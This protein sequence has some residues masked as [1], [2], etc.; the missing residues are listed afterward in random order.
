MNPSANPP[1]TTHLSIR[2]DW[3]AMQQ[4]DIIEPELPIVDA[5]H[6]LWDHLGNRY[7]L[8][9]MLA[10][11]SSGHNIRATVGVEC[12]SMY[13]QN[14][15]SELRPVGETEFLNGAAAMSAS[16]AYGE[17]RVAHGIVG[18]AN[19]CLGA[20]VKPVLEAHIRAGGGRFRGVRFSSVWHPDPAARGSLA[21]PPPFV[22]RDPKFQEGFAQ[23]APLGLSFDAW[24][25]HTQLPE[26][27]EL[28]QRFPETTIIL[29]HIGGAIGIGPYAGKRDAVLAEWRT[30]M[31]ELAGLKNVY[32]KLGGLG[33]RLAGFDFSSRARPPSSQ[34]L[35]VCWRPFI[36]TCI[37]IFGAERC[38]FE[39]NFPVDKGS[40][41]YAVLW[42]AFKRLA[43]DASF[44][45]KQALFSGTASKVYRL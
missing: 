40:F 24:L 12:N 41:S 37:E 38:M 17:C 15:A 3:L 25:Y 30:S 27:V 2:P 22:M 18:H 21:N 32:V 26:L 20:S 11:I 34:E 7:F 39:S 4:E 19:L 44:E 42:N 31:R 43:A 36:D 14:A 23:L 29:N 8:H 5:H 10:D 6:H 33:M 45:D 28:A 13:S 9:D 35:A 16:G 1:T